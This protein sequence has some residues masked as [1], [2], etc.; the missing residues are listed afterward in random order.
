MAERYGYKSCEECF[1]ECLGFTRMARCD[2]A[3]AA[4][5]CMG[6]SMS[7]QLLRPVVPR[8]SWMLACKAER[9]RNTTIMSYVCLICMPPK[10][11]FQF[12]G[13]GRP[14]GYPLHLGAV[15]RSLHTIALALLFMIMNPD[16]NWLLLMDQSGSRRRPISRWPPEMSTHGALKN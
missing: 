9:E 16:N 13:P 11:R 3:T 10:T 1:M 12:V 7:P 2:G 5:V 6:S 8:E 4:I 14:G 15:G